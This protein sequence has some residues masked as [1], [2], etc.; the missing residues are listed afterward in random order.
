MKN[1]EKVIFRI[2]GR[3][4]VIQILLIAII[5][6]FAISLAGIIHIGTYSNMR[7][8][9]KKE[10]EEYRLELSASQRAAL[11]NSITINWCFDP[12]V[13]KR[14]TVEKVSSGDSSKFLVN[15][16]KLET[17]EINRLDDSHT[18][19]YIDYK[20]SVNPLF[21]VGGAINEH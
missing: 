15:I 5:G 7:V 13:G 16:N 10:G 3:F 12:L 8:P 14:Y 1:R 2:T 4:P 19:I 17:D 20:T 9:V 21:K 6:T 11:E 18:M